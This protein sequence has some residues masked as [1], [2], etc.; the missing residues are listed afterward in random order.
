MSALALV[1]FLTQHVN[2]IFPSPVAIT[3]L[4][5]NATATNAT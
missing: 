5:N 3:T 4:L 1:I 2:V